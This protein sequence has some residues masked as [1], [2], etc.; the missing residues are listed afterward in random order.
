MVQL[1]IFGLQDFST[2]FKEYTGVFLESASPAKFFEE[3]QNNINRAVPMPHRLKDYLGREKQAI[4][5]NNNFNEL[6]NIL[7]S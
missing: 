7:L 6:K 5:V 4:L 1:L 2:K 3:V